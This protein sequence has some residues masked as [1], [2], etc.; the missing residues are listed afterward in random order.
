[1]AKPPLSTRSMAVT[2]AAAQPNTRSDAEAWLEGLK[3]PM[4]DV[5]LMKSDG[6]WST[7]KHV[8]DPTTIFETIGMTLER[9]FKYAI[10]AYHGRWALC[11]RRH[12]VR[13]FDAKEA[14][15]MVAIHHG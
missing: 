14:A 7:E 3:I 5:L 9:G 2:L 8:D 4:I 6:V 13:Y 12:R 15:E 11:S 10:V 1:M